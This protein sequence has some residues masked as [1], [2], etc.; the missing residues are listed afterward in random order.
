MGAD[1]DEEVEAEAEADA[2]A[3]D[4]VEASMRSSSEGMHGV[5]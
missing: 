1:E 4:R 5:T 3:D 2:E